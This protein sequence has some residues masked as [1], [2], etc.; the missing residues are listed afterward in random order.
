M[1]QKQTQE[2]SQALAVT[3]ET[4]PTCPLPDARYLFVLKE[5]IC[6]RNNCILFVS[7]TTARREKEE[8]DSKH[9]P[10]PVDRLANLS[11]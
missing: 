1:A 9:P 2:T 6:C 10:V 8:P 7:T 5:H 11:K 4:L 3:L